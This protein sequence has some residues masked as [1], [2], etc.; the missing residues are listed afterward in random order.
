MGRTPR[1]PGSVPPTV[2]SIVPVRIDPAGPVHIDIASH[3]R[4]VIKLATAVDHTIISL[5]RLKDACL[6]CLSTTLPLAAPA[7]E[8]PIQH[9]PGPVLPA[10]SAPAIP[11]QTV[12]PASKHARTKDPNRPA[13]PM[14][15]YL[16]FCEDIRDQ[17]REQNPSFGPHDVAKTIGQLWKTMAD[18]ERMP[19]T[20]RYEAAKAKYD[21]AIE[22]YHQNQ[23]PKSLQP[24][25][26]V[27]PGPPE[28]K[29]KR[30]YNRNPNIPPRP[31]TSFII[32]S[33]EVRERLRHERPNLKPHEIVKTIGVLWRGLSDQ[34]R[35]PYLDQYELKMRTYKAAKDAYQGLHD[36]GASGSGSAPVATSLAASLSGSMVSDQTHSHGHLPMTGTETAVASIYPVGFPMFQFSNMIASSEIPLAGPSNNN[37]GGDAIKSVGNNANANQGGNSPA[38]LQGTVAA[39]IPS[40]TPVPAPLAPV[41]NGKTRVRPAARQTQSATKASTPAKAKISPKTDTSAQSDTATSKIEKRKRKTSNAP[42]TQPKQARTRKAQS[43]NQSESAAE[44]P[45]KRGRRG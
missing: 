13:R 11:A 23:A 17:V 19:Y 16:M 12:L 24:I 5:Q 42:A 39:S 45:T 27:K 38:T 37:N 44:P 35:Q 2:P 36:V 21:A 18:E 31:L 43:E 8:P 22:E 34:E 20:T 32:F 14:T 25:E 26:P 30:R 33:N 7:S 1:N 10:V 3:Q 15:S 41:R 40:P 29:A 4:T 9:S 28:A 6:E